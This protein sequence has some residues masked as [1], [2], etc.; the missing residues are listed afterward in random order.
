MAKFID[1]GLIVIGA[2]LVVYGVGRVDVTAAII[3]CGLFLMVGGVLIGM[4]GRIAK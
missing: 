1:D 3:V 2:S 4:A